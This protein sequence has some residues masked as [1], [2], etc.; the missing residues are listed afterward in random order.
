[1]S[2]EPD[3]KSPHEGVPAPVESETAAPTKAPEVST[4]AGPASPASEP[5]AA[6]SGSI[7]VAL[8]APALPAAASGS[9]EPGQIEA[10]PSAPEL[11]V[12]KPDPA[13]PV[14]PA[15]D[16]DSAPVS[17]GRV[18]AMSV[19]ATGPTEAARGKRI[20]EGAKE[21]L[22]KS[23]ETL[24][25]GIETI[26]EGI[27][28][29]GD[30]S[31]K[32]PIVGSSVARLGEGIVSVGESI[33]DLP[34]V[35]RTRRGRLLV[36]SVFVGFVL[37]F[38]WIA[39]IVLLQQRRTDAPDFRPIAEQILSQLG[40][41]RA[42]IEEQYEKASPRFQEMVRKERFVDDMLDLNA[43][44]GQ[45]VEITSINESLV[46]RG[47]SGRIGR[48]SMSV[49]Y[50][51]GNTRAS[52]SLHWDDDRWKLLGIGVEVPPDVKITNAQREERVAACKDPM[53]SKRCD[54]HIAANQILEQLR[55]GHAALV[56]DKA[57]DVFQ[58]QLQKTQFVQI[59]A[60]QQEVL[61][62]YRRIIAVTEAK[63]IAGTRGTYDVL[64]EYSR[65]NVRVIFGFTRA[66]K[67]DPW[68]LR[69]LKIALPMPRLDDVALPPPAGSGSGSGAGSG[70]ATAKPGSAAKS[71]KRK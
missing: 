33:T 43:T 11:P 51:K 18:T 21:M 52:V 25:T 17:S 71:A 56:W 45:F 1:M 6:S 48:L 41:G 27:E 28:K 57:N 26:G 23:V 58:K 4:D 69:S 64:V 49:A 60:E 34:R 67:T 10:A 16:L 20:T 32:V 63:V 8:S 15:H 54:I 35:A 19:A 24:G 70:S 9:S 46:T 14:E 22:G 68:T 65:A 40:K 42:A 7:D 31:K 62:E 55:D 47:P 44:V 61:G 13:A 29:L 36:R 2:S 39:A 3:P 5:A 30:V 50:A 38:S 59:V 66:S 12:A 53:D 37:V